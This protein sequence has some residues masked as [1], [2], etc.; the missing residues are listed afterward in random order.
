[1]MSK[2][3]TLDIAEMKDRAKKKIGK[4]REKPIPKLVDPPAA[5]S[6]VNSKRKRGKETLS[7]YKGI[8]LTFS[9]EASLYS[10]QGSLLDSFDGLLFPNDIKCFEGLGTTGAAYFVLYM[11]QQ[12]SSQVVKM[13]DL[14]LEDKTFRTV[15]KKLK[16]ELHCSKE[17]VE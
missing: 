10:D 7:D 4:S 8:S 13:A 5:I 12:C 2:S 3:F 1:M 15:E 9:E 16:D 11:R 17:E 6:K 14:Q